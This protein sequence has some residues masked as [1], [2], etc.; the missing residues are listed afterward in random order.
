MSV[1]FLL[2][3]K[4]FNRP[5]GEIQSATE[6]TDSDSESEEVNSIYPFSLAVS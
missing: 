2:F 6:T 1:F 4:I 3:F 5:A